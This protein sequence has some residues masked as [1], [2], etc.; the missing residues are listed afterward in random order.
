[1]QVRTFFRQQTTITQALLEALRKQSGRASNPATNRRLQ[2]LLALYLGAERRYLN[3]YGPP[4]TIT[5]LSYD[6]VLSATPAQM[7]PFKDKVVFIGFSEE[8]QP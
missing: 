1:M 5:T 6:E 3:F 7:T 2:A 4:R 8:R